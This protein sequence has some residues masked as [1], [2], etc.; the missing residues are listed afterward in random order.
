[1]PVDA[2]LAQHG[3][4]ALGVEGVLRH[5]RHDS[6]VL[7]HVALADAASDSLLQIRRTIRDVRQMD[8]GKPLLHI[9]ADTK[10]HVRAEHDADLAVVHL[11]RKLVLL[12]FPL[13]NVCDLLARDAFFHE[14]VCDPFVQCAVILAAGHALVEEN[15][16]RS[17]D[18]ARSVI[19]FHGFR[20][21]VSELFAFLHAAAFVYQ[22]PGNRH[23]APKALHGQR[24]DF[25][26]LALVALLQQRRQL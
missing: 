5:I 25:G 11:F 7:V 16:L 8:H 6:D 4:P 2:R 22:H 26:I 14:P 10:L 1:M 19:L 3:V 21:D 23:V 17:L 9:D 20:A 12:A 15:K 13:V 24:V 18:V